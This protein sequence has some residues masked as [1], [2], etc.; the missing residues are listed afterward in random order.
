L[1]KNVLHKLN[2]SGCRRI[3]F[4]PY[5]IVTLRHSFDF[6]I[7]AE[8][9]L[10]KGSSDREVWGKMMDVL[11]G[12]REMIDASVLPQMAEPLCYECIEREGV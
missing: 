9:D 3:S 7:K 8:E 12:I 6:H 5:T 10:L 4:D 11:S 1:R 2:S